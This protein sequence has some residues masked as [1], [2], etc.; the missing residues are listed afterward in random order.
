MS[1]ILGGLAMENEQIYYFGSVINGKEIIGNGRKDL[2]IVNPYNGDVIGKISCATIQDVEDAIENADQ[3][4]NDTM[5]KMPAHERSTI[6]RKT[7]DL[8]EGK[9]EQFTKVLTLEAGKPIQE[10]RGE[11]VRAVQ[12]LR[13]SSELAKNIS[14][15]QIP[16]D[17]AIG[18]ENQ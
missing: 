12:V 16:L 13:F 5:K 11:V 10:S 1:I 2:E 18:A 6:L 17:S 9:F 3:V 4:Y 8:L 7:A 14:G 15:E